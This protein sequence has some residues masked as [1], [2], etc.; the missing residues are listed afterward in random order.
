MAEGR[1]QSSGSAF[2]RDFDSESE[3]STLKR[4]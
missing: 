3:R 4:E 1:L 2:H